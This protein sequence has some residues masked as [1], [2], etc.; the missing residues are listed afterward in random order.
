MNFEL[1]T[2]FMNYKRCLISKTVFFLLAVC[3][4]SPFITKAEVIF[5][6]IDYIKVSDGTKFL[7]FPWAGGLNSAQF[8]DPDLNNDGIKD[9]LVYEKTENR[10]L[11]FLGDEQ[12]NYRL[13]RNH[14]KHIP[15]I[16]GWVITKD[17]NCDET[18][19]LFTYHNGSIRIY[20]G[21][22][23]DDT[24]KF[25]LW[26]DEINYE[27]SF[28]TINL[29]SSFVDRPAIADFDFDGDLDILT[30]NVSANRMVLY[31]NMRI[32]KGLSCDD[33]SFILKDN[34][35]GNIY[36]SGL[37]PVVDMR[38]TCNN[39]INNAR[40]DESSKSF[41]VGSTLEAA[42]I[43]GR[44]VLDVLMGD[45]SLQLVNHL[46]NNGDRR[47]AS[48]L[49]QDTLYPSYDVPARI[50]SFPLITFIDVNQDGIKD[51]LIT[52]FEGLGVDNYENVLYYKGTRKD[53]VKLSFISNSFM[54]GEMIDVGENA[55]P[56]LIDINGDGL[57]DLIVGGTFRKNNQINSRIHYYKNIGNVE[58]PA[59]Q[60]ID[61]DFLGFSSLGFQ[62]PHP[63]AGDLDGD[64]K[65][66]LLIGLQDGRILFYKNTSSD[67]GFKTDHYSVLKNND[68]DLD[69]GLNAA[70]FLADIDK[71]GKNE[72]FVGSYH[73][74]IHL[75]NI[76]VTNEQ[77]NL[78]HLTDSVGKITTTAQFMP[79]GYSSISIADID[80]D[81][82]L[83]MVIGGYDNYLKWVSNI[84]DSIYT[85]THPKKLASLPQKIGRQIAPH[86]EDITNE[87]D[88]TLL[89]GLQTG[90][91]RWLSI[92]PPENIHVGVKE[93]KNSSINF[94]VYPNPNKG[95]FTVRTHHTNIYLQILNLTGQILYTEKL[96]GTETVINFSQFPAGAYLIR[97]YN[98]N[99]QTGNQLFIKN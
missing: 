39:K 55:V 15:E 58:S 52:P 17:M 6:E 32:E 19:D 81:G 22:Y 27:S 42:D 37:S 11:T 5:H 1:K 33:L 30:F 68:T 29:Y 43:R 21:Y 3:F 25:E 56:T 9:L 13:D 31:Q 18:H 53:Q 40:I 45:A 12:G 84:E 57:K 60:L 7:D 23:E 94:T 16:E 85:K 86:F 98:K 74:N 2:L 61:D 34:C 50:T 87:N 10:V 75:Y 79:F 82:Q 64:G 46:Y 88:G 69:V 8:C 44:G 65:K 14:I 89:L 38:D 76:S 78:Q 80:K 51:L 77:I 72:L 59:F 83:D 35:W 24:L 49:S 67:E 93:N 62:S 70:P 26:A 47:Y 63:H 66:D 99:L 91:I 97:L 71:D 73:G 96:S 54:V 4:I 90:G 28:G 20:R 48:I 36:E 95:I 41:H 92:Y